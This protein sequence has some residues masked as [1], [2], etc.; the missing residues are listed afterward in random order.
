MSKKL[1]QM[2]IGAPQLLQVQSMHLNFGISYSQ[3]P[4]FT[5]EEREFRI[6]AM[7]EELNE[8]RDAKNNN[9]SL[10]AIID[11]IV[12]ALGTIE[13]QGWAPIFAEAFTN[14]MRANNNKT[15][16]VSPNNKR[17][18]FKL[19]LVKPEGWQAPDHTELLR[20]VYNDNGIEYSDG[21]FDS[22][23]VKVASTENSTTCNSELTSWDET[24]I[25][26]MLNKIEFIAPYINIKKITKNS[27]VEAYKTWQHE[28]RK[29][30]C[31]EDLESTKE[32]YEELLKNNI[33]F[34]TLQPGESP[35][36]TVY[37]GPGQW[38]GYISETDFISKK[39]FESLIADEIINTPFHGCIRTEG[40]SIFSSKLVKEL[41]EKANNANNITAEQ[42]T[43]KN[44]NIQVLTPPKFS[45]IDN[46]LV[47]RG[48]RYGTYI[49]NCNYI[50]DTNADILSNACMSAIQDN[51]LCETIHLIVCK[52]ARIK[53]GDITYSDNYIDII[54]YCKLYLQALK[55][56]DTIDVQQ[57]IR[58]TEFNS[59]TLE[60]LN[61]A[62]NE[63]IVDYL[64]LTV[65]NKKN[66]NISNV[67]N[68]PSFY[69]VAKL[70]DY[71]N[72]HL[73]IAKIISFTIARMKQLNLN[74]ENLI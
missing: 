17:N 2:V 51:L 10:D 15:V 20:K 38:C 16:G 9:E 22:E 73:L 13:R 7:Q 48:T 74:T 53:N 60:L 52:L 43:I 25:Q 6:K 27:I 44:I 72:A 3:L 5:N 57:I 41:L 56:Y 49:S 47:E 4:I 63:I 18:G 70:S 71:S 12:F 30:H 8:Y 29:S 19:D 68:I 62:Y 1:N 39:L 54:G 45:E 36:A 31:R 58:K 46:I 28:Y 37:V 26:N 69:L 40:K 66:S 21:T 65:I 14:V 23:L 67:F 42:P 59:Q 32:F 61:Y 24:M 64:A 50:Q 35:I 33:T 55:K 11:L 34:K